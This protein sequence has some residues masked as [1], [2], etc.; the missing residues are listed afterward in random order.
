ML[1]YQAEETQETLPELPPGVE[2]FEINGSF[3]FG[4]ARKFTETLLVT[5]SGRRVVILRMRHVLAIDATGLHALEDVFSR[6]QR[7]GCRVLL[8][9]VHAQPLMAMTRSGS[10]ARIGAGNLLPNLHAAVARARQLLG[11]SDGSAGSDVES[12]V[13]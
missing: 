3:C 2:V 5:Q 9:G 12:E 4:A 13:E 11:E 10:L 1:D 8:S 7:R 6:L